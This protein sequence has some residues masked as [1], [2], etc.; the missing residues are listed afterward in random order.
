MPAVMSSP[1]SCLFSQSARAYRRS[2]RRARRISAY[3]DRR[4]DLW[5]TPAYRAAVRWAPEILVDGLR[6]RGHEVEAIPHTN[7]VS[8]SG[9]D[10]GHVH[11]LSWGAI[12]ASTDRT[13][14]PFA[15]H[16][17]PHT[18]R[19]AVRQRSLWP[20]QTGSLR[21]G[22]IRPMRSVGATASPAQR[23]RSFRTESTRRSFRSPGLRHRATG[24]G[25]CSAWDS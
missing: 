13:N 11:H 19:A 18:R 15:F 16:F 17:T 6:R 25:S 20:A 9:F 10:I 24:P 3:R 1:V 5:S 8:L 21:S 2:R 22:R 4:W 7:R 12:A 14:T 23:S